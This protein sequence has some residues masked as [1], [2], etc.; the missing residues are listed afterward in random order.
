MRAVG[1]FVVFSV[2]CGPSGGGGDDDDQTGG[3]AG[4]DPDA[5]GAP[6]VRVVVDP[7]LP[8]DIPGDFDGFAF[9]PGLDLVYP[10]PGAVIPRDV[11]ALDAQGRAEPGLQ[12]YRI[13]FDVDTGDALRGYVTQASWLPDDS[14][15]AWLM[16]RAA[17][18]TITL[19]I[20]GATLDGATALLSDGQ[21]LHVSVDEATGALFY[22]A[23]TGDQVGGEGV[24][25][26]LELGSRQPARYLDKTNSG[27]NCVGC[28]TLSRDGARLSFTLM[29]ALYQLSS[30]LV[31]AEDPTAR[32]TAQGASGANGA[33]NPDGSRLL[34][35]SA[36]VLELYDAA[37]GAKLATIPT[38]GPA[39]YPDWSWDGSRIVFVRPEALCA[40][41]LLDFGQDSIFV[42]GGSLV[43]MDHG[44]GTSFS[45]EQVLLAADGS[46]SNT[47]PSFSPDGSWIAFTRVAR[48][49]TSSW[50]LGNTA[51]TGQTG[52]GVSYDN[53]SADVWLIAPDGGAPLELASATETGMLTNSW[54]RWAPK[55]DG[56]YLW[57]SLSSK[58]EY[59]LR[60]TGGA[61]HHQLW[62]TAVRKPTEP[63]GDDPSAPAVWFPF[64]TMD[65]KNHL[66]QWSLKVGDFEID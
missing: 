27:G 45:N 44:G 13:A 38:A 32:T 7:S 59:G 41:N 49:V 15:W 47:Y 33:F 23:T 20:A 28:H 26:R 30:A 61:A 36:G 54:P 10:N 14:D 17:G 40:P 3:D 24:L 29:D 18:H 2:A 19:T 55:A 64:Q 65:T 52:A 37:T 43:T 16:N 48:S 50:D 53:P 66:G 62:F 1:L 4:S 46:Y 8:P 63:F 25:E 34:M 6:V 58:R 9:T 51:C 31:A 22:F 42:Y 39:L 35:A 60:I 21:P 11:A 56:E 57:L 12:V 5:R